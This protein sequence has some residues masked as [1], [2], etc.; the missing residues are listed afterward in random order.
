MAT[1]P[2]SHHHH[3]ETATTVCMAFLLLHPIHDLSH[4]A[5]PLLLI[6]VHIHFPG[7]PSCRPSPF[8]CPF[9][10]LAP[11][12]LFQIHSKFIHQLLLPFLAGHGHEDVGSA[13]VR[14]QSQDAAVKVGTEHCC[15]EE[16]GGGCRQLP[17]KLLLEA[18]YIKL[19]LL[20]L[21]ASR[22]C[23]LHWH[24]MPFS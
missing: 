24:G 4:L 7:L 10:T 13:I 5:A 21:L 11:C 18:S 17:A 22:P 2:G 1:C 3:V 15:G 16:L 23:M 12:F 9:Q 19:K 6:G 20:R 8:A 14:H